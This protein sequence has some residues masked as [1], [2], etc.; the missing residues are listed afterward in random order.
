VLRESSPVNVAGAVSILRLKVPRGGEG[1]GRLPSERERHCGLSTVSLDA[2]GRG[3]DDA[4]S[5][6]SDYGDS[7]ETKRARRKS[8]PAPKKPLQPCL[9]PAK[10]NLNGPKVLE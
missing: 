3:D 5:G 1:H 4:Y 10:A 2:A 9:I 6:Y 8:D 7:I